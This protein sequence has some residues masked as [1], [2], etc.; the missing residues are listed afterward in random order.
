MRTFYTP[1]LAMLLIL[2]TTEG[3]SMSENI[4]VKLE[5]A[6]ETQ[7]GWKKDQIEVIE[8]EKIEIP[9]CHFFTVTEKGSMD[10]YGVDFA[11]LSDGRAISADHE[12]AAS[13]ILAACN[14]SKG[15]SPTS[16]AELITR[17]HLRIGPVRV[18]YDEAQAQAAIE[19]LK[20]GGKSFS[21][22]TL[23]SAASGTTIKFCVMNYERGVLSKITAT[24]KKGGSMDVDVWQAP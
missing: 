12:D 20:K 9:G 10:P 7:L 22:P 21:P 6:V 2:L 14:A 13:T 3:T 8:L 18:L 11:L 24:Y 1:V 19:S 17:F 5:T 23:E 16:W 15:L 4:R